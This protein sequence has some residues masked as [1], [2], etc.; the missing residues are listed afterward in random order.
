MPT[1]D[2]KWTL[3]QHSAYGYKG[4]GMFRRAVEERQ[5][6]SQREVNRVLKAGGLIFDD[7]GAASDRAEVENYPDPEH[8]GL[9]P[10]CPGVFHRDAVDGLHIYL[11]ADSSGAQAVLQMRKGAS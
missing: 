7:Y 11:P 5:L 1:F 8:M 9:I 3:V 4:D 10:R 6:E 2:T